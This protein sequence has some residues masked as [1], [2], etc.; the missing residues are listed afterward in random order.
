M[1]NII[2]SPEWFPNKENLLS[3]IF[4]KKHIEVIAKTNNVV[5]AFAVGTVGEDKNYNLVIEKNV[6]TSVICYFR[7]SKLPLIGKYI[8]FINYFLADYKAIKQ[9]ELLIEKVDFFHIHVLPK[10]AV[11]PYLYYLFKNVPY[12]ISEHSTAYLR[13]SNNYVESWLKIKFANNSKGLSAVSESLKFAMENKGLKHQNFKI[14]PNVIN[15]NIFSLKPLNKDTKIKFLHVSRLDEQAKNVIGILRVF[16]L[17]YHKYQQIELHIVG[18]F[19]DMVSDAELFSKALKCTEAV[20]FHGIKYGEDIVPYYHNADYFVMFSNYETQAVVVVEALMCGLP[21]IATQLPA[22]DEYLHQ[23]NSIQ[24]ATKDESDL[25]LK[26]E[27][28][29]NKTC[30]FWPAENI[31]S[32]IKLKF[33]LNSLEEGFKTLYKLGMNS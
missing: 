29:I 27:N 16:E 24:V 33:D 32:D 25:Y 6:F 21:V 5:V 31:S 19:L 2:V 12:F 3:A 14:I 22:L 13:K 1:Y 11:I 18:G 10:S 26:M 9:A 4:T 17:L 23:Y 30:D 7:L 28:C 20:F 8:N 15:P